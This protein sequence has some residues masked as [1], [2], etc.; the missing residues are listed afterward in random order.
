MDADRLDS[1]RAAVVPRGT[2]GTES[3]SRSQGSA[4][5]AVKSGLTCDDWSTTTVPVPCLSRCRVASIDLERAERA[6]ADLLDAL[7][8]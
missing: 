1:A 3:S 2:S 8:S 6:V 5:P 7:G 4:P